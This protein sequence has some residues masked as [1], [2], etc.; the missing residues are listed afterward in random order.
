[1]RTAAVAAALAAAALIPPAPAGTAPAFRGA[2]LGGLLVL[3][4]G[5]LFWSAD[6]VFA[7]LGGRIPAPSFESLVQRLVLFALV[8][9]GALGLAL[10]A[11]ER[12]PDRKWPHRRPLSRPAGGVPPACLHVPFF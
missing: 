11:R 5:A 9:F 8:L 4:F 10:A 12:P 7:E 6:A 1:M 2:L 3:P